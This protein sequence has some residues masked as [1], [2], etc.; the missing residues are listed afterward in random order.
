MAD[1]FPR[2][3]GTPPSGLPPATTTAQVEAINLIQAELH[4]HELAIAADIQSC[5]LPKKV[6]RVAGLDLSAYYQ[7]CHYIGGDYYDFIEIDAEHLGLAVADV[8][9]K[10]VP[11]ALVM[12]QARTLMRAMAVHFLSPRDVMI[13]MNKQLA[14]DIP[15]GMFVTMFYALLNIPQWTITVCSAGHN[16]MLYWRRRAGQLGYVNTRGLALGIDK[17]KLFEKTVEELM[18]QFEPG[19]RFV[20]YT[21]GLTE[22]M[23]P[24]YQMFE[25]K[26]VAQ[27]FQSFVKTDCPGFLKTLRMSLNDFCRE[28]PQ[29]DDITLVA[30]RRL[31]GVAPGPQE[32][33]TI[34]DGERFIQCSFCEAVNPTEVMRC[35][36]CGE[37]LG[38]AGFKIQLQLK[39]DEVECTGC[40]RIFNLRKYPRACPYCKRPLCA[41]CRR[42]TTSVGAFCDTCGQKK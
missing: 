29:H 15:K 2:R 33:R 16:P 17:G 37:P 4:R 38:S 7:P 3:L 21:D 19:D 41:R 24:S 1:P 40:R 18:L 13:R 30:A 14:G 5:M 9:G 31:E 39:E 6:P 42:R 25:L 22:A 36:I 35:K 27:A 26:R 12:A 8:S 20:I 10:G 11:G 32:P 28:A 34:L 23:N